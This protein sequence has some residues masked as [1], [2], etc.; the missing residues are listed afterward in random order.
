MRKNLSDLSENPTYANPTYPRFTVL[1][2]IQVL[3]L[4]YFIKSRNT[5]REYERI[6][7]GMYSRFFESHE[8]DKFGGER[9]DNRKQHESLH[10]SRLVHG[11]IDS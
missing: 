7:D 9:A 1:P 10:E 11:W 8:K 5:Y 6:L 4:P 3:I 2:I